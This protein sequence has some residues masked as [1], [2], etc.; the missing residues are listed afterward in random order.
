[1]HIF[2]AC[3]IEPLGAEKSPFIGRFTF[4]TEALLSAVSIAIF[5]VHSPLVKVVPLSLTVDVAMSAPSASFLR[6]EV[7]AV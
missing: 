2:D 6:V 7:V 3:P 5:Y 4:K 1:M